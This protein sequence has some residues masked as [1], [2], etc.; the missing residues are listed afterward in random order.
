MEQRGA[1]EVFELLD[2]LRD[3]RFGDT[4]LPR[5]I[6][7]ALTL[8]YAHERLHTEEPVYDATPTS[9]LPAEMLHEF[10]P[11]RDAPRPTR[12]MRRTRPPRESQIL[13]AAI[14]FSSDAISRCVARSFGRK[15]CIN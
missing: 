9:R 3:N 4:K 12:T 8:R 14:Q 6:S 10:R 2:A 5:R 13:I 11:D 15:V 7:E 1:N